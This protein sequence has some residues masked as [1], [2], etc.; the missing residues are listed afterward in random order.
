VTQDDVTLT[1]AIDEWGEPHLTI[2]TKGRP[3]KA[4]PA[5]LK[6]QPDIVALLNRKREI[7]QQASRMRQSLEQAM[8]RGD[9][10][11]GAELKQL[12][13]HPVL[14]PM[15]TQLVFIGDSI[16]GYPSADGQHLTGIKGQRYPLDPNVALR[17]AH[18]HD[19]LL[20]NEWHIWQAECFSH[21]YIQPFKQ[22]FR[23]LYVPTAAETAQATA[24]H[25]YA[26]HQVNARQA[27]ALLGQRGWVSHP[28][29]GIRRTFHDEGIAAWL[30]CQNGYFTPAEVEGL[31]LEGIHFS[32]RGEWKPLP[33]GQIPP[34]L[35][36]EIMRDLDL[37]VSV[38]H[39][40]GVDPEA[41]ASTVE[42][43]TALIRETCTLLGLDNVRLKNNHALIEGKLNHYSV[44]IGSG[45]VHQQPGGYLCLVAVHSQQRGRIFLPF[46]DNDPKT[47]EVISKVLLLAQDDNIK[48]SSILEQI[49][50]LGTRP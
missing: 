32:R 41:S 22:I 15:L 39:Q 1:L 36:S 38:A 44:H 31:T 19:L 30:S 7:K 23:E 49:L 26:G 42:M 25:R 24:S 2:I 3:L 9:V 29:E 10:F 28:G 16:M 47:A 8:C 48:D 4:V 6:K 43:R 5:K 11:T 14:K 33:I 12:L 37:V 35:F 21:E 18:P 40:G 17:L 27:S 46:A 13:A 50:P 45:V 34:R 20:S